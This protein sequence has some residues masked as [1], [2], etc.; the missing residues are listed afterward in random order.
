M[1]IQGIRSLLRDETWLSLCSYKLLCK[2]LAR[3]FTHCT[4]VSPLA[5]EAELPLPR[6]HTITSMATLPV[7]HLARERTLASLSVLSITRR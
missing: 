2:L 5:A 7:A 1:T 4:T 6:M 3:F